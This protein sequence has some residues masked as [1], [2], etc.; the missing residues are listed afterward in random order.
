MGNGDL[1]LQ[2]R[3]AGVRRS[4]CAMRTWHRKHA[5]VRPASDFSAGNRISTGCGNQTVS[6]Y[7]IRR[8]PLQARESRQTFTFAGGKNAAGQGKARCN[9]AQSKPLPGSDLRPGAIC[10]CPA[11]YAMG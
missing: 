6:A 2:G 9:R 3:I 10:S 1:A 5:G 11:R 4:P 7:A 8:R